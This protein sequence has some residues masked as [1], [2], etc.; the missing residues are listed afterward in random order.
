MLSSRRGDAEFRD[1]LGNFWDRG[2]GGKVPAFLA[3]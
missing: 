2:V 1:D 3:Y